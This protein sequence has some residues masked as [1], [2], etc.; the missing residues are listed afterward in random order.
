MGVVG[1]D[2]FGGCVYL[3]DSCVV[4]DGWVLCWVYGNIW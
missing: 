3:V 1:V 4:C 2:C